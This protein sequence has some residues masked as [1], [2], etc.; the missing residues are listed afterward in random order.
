M[1]HDLDL[2]AEVVPSRAT[3]QKQVRCEVLY[4][5]GPALPNDGT[6][7]VGGF[8]ATTCFFRCGVYLPGYYPLVWET[9]IIGLAANIE[10][11]VERH[12]G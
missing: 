3:L 7:P 2:K 8:E 6:V 12:G 1:L 4:H 5:R 10:I 11:T 9:I